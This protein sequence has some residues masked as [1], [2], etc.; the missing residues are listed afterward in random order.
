MIPYLFLLFVA[1]TIATNA[2]TPLHVSSETYCAPPQDPHTFIA[3]HPVALDCLNLATFIL[4][5]TPNH[6]DPIQL[7]NGATAGQVKTPWFRTSGTCVIT[8]VSTGPDT[9]SFD[10]ILRIVL[11]LVGNC[12]LDNR[13]LEE[14]WGGNARFGVNDR[15]SMLLSGTL[16]VGEAEGGL[17]NVT[18]ALDDFGSLVQDLA[19]S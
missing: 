4:A 19:Q 10:E 2:S 17:G 6:A 9:T 11:E 18:L 3:R 1:S 8:V 14:H 5:T 12:F 7:S 16:K 15:L 13:P